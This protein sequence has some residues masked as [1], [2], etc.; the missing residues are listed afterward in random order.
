MLNS[1]MAVRHWLVIPVYNIGRYRANKYKSS[2]DG[3]KLASN[4]IQSNLARVKLKTLMVL[5]CNSQVFELSVKPTT[6]CPF[7]HPLSEISEF[8]INRFYC[9]CYHRLSEEMK[10]LICS[11]KHWSLLAERY[12]PLKK[13]RPLRFKCKIRP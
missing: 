3:V 4:M 13:L 9:S 8:E 1:F 7:F 11:G 6:N 12:S 2:T 10:Y 5:L